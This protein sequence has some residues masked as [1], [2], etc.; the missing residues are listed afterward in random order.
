MTTL[1]LYLDTRRAK[2]GGVYPIKVAVRKEGKAA[3]IPTRF[4]ALEREW[5]SRTQS[6]KGKAS[7]APINAE[8]RQIVAD[9]SAKLARIQDEGLTASHVRDL[10]IQP[11]RDNRFVPRFLDYMNHCRAEGTRGLYLATYK[12][13]VAYDP[14][15]ERRRFEDITKDWLRGFDS[16]L[17]KT[18]CVNT[19]SINLRN[20]RTV[21][22]DAIDNDITQW[23][24]FRA[25]KIRQ[26][27][28]RHRALSVEDLRRLRDCPVPEWMEE[29]RQMFL[30]MVYLRGINAA[31]LFMAYQ[32]NLVD[33]RLEYRRKKTSRLYSVKVEPE[34]MQIIERYKGHGHLLRVCDHWSDYRCYLAH[35]NRALKK[36]GGKEGKYHRLGDGWFPELSSY[37]ARHT[38]A[39]IAAEIGIPMDTISLMLGHSFGKSVTQIY[40]RHDERKADEAMRKVIDYIQKTSHA[41]QRGRTNHVTKTKR[42]TL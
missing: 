10:L 5:D 22:N 41:S 35:M 13:M 8:L 6:V 2:S 36:I 21:F 25:F 23:Y 7:A 9:Y 30:L 34:A 3:Y 39:S 26:E 12:L 32:I 15:L 18:Q 33:G 42:K 28:T 37:W 20:I 38:V 4:S 14:Q 16:F 1:S 24:P 40:V 11:E 19:R 17:A 29:Y 27:A 31:D